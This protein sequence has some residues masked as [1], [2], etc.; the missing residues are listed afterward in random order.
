VRAPWEGIDVTV[1]ARS[2]EESRLDV[3][4]A[5]ETDLPET[6]PDLER[7]VAQ[8]GFFGPPDDRL[9]AGSYVITDGEVSCARTG[10][11]LGPRSTV[12][13]NTYFGRFPAS[14]WQRWT[15]ISEAVLEVAVTGAGRITVQASDRHGSARVL[16]THC[17]D[18]AKPTRID[19]P[20]VVD[21]FVDGGAVWAEFT[22]GVGE[23]LRVDDVRW[24]VT[25]P[26]TLRPTALVMCTHNR[27]DDCVATLE[28]FARDAEARLMVDAVYVVD[29]GD[30]PVESRPEFVGISEDLGSSLH[31][32]RQP[33]LGGAGGFTRGLYEVAEVQGAD[34][35]N[36][37]FM[38]DD[39]LLEPDVVVR[40]TAFAN[41]TVEPVIVGAQMLHLLHPEKLHV[42]AETARFTTIE[43][44]LPVDDDALNK[45]DIT[46][47]LQD[48]RVD[49]DYNAWW[50]CLISSEIVADVGYPM[51]FFFQWDDVEFGYRARARGHASITLPGAAV[52][53]HDFDWKD[54]DDWTRYFTLRNALMI[55]ALHGAFDPAAS[56]RIAGRWIAECLA[57]MRYGEAATLI[58]AVEDFLRGPDSLA[59]GGVAALHAVRQLRR[60]YPETQRHPAA[61]VPGLPAAGRP[62]VRAGHA[63]SR[64]AAVL[65][66]RLV[67]QLRGRVGGT[68]SISAE[69]SAWW[70]VSRFHTAVVTDRSQEGVRLR[71]FDREALL[72][73]GR[74]AATVLW[75][76]RRDGGDARERLLVAV[77]EL[78]SRAHWQK[79]FDL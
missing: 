52:W 60:N 18:D 22:T 68:V 9:P 39:I 14:Y 72:R 67:W 25:A 78:T 20:V 36:V 59:D 21:R 53:H 79:L 8:R 65:A 4:V 15:S 61:S 64:P 3:E 45:T 69:D 70:H 44:G 49:S 37:L 31:Y 43:P 30:D 46:K 32:R 41:R 58:L 34:A 29:Q 16:A 27:A 7:L 76:L 11:V 24:S 28:T 66:K 56:A 13:Q 75:R 62:R 63:P 35:A 12:S 40:L 73:L 2:D 47:E 48:I 10:A 6:G 1:R 51:P 71:R 23:H 38:D 42:S 77:P 26:A 57:S 33:N 74:E 19:V 50:T 5:G 55:D 54:E 17:A